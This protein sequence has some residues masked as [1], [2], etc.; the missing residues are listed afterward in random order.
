MMLQEKGHTQTAK[1][2]SDHHI[3]EE[4]LFSVIESICEVANM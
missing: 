2:Q 4:T 3:S 1:R